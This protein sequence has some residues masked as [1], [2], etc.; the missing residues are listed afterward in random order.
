MFAIH[1]FFLF[2]SFFLLRVVKNGPRELNSCLIATET[3]NKRLMKLPRGSYSHRQSEMSECLKMRKCIKARWIRRIQNAAQTKAVMDSAI[4]TKTQCFMSTE[5]N[6]WIKKIFS[7]S[8][9]AST[10]IYETMGVER[11]SFWIGIYGITII[12]HITRDGKN[13]EKFRSTRDNPLSST[14]PIQ[15]L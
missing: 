7:N 8:W 4:R 3:A 5:H 14:N 11:E 2:G 9:R 15:Y 10:H 6:A 13:T 12:A 1:C